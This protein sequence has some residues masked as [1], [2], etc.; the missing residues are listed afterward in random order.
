MTFY[1][2]K[3]SGHTD[4]IV[5]LARGVVRTQSNISDGGFLRNSVRLLTVNYFRKNPPP[6]M[7]DWVLTTPLLTIVFQ[8]Y[9]IPV[10]ELMLVRL[11]AGPTLNILRVRHS[12]TSLLSKNKQKFIWMTFLS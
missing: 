9:M 12:D 10:K 11:P 5:D 3:N 1:I 2:A 8:Y 4:L 7:A 6:Y